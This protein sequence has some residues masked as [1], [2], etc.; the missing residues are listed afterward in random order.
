MEETWRPHHVLP[1]RKTMATLQRSNVNGV[2]GN[3]TRRAAVVVSPGQDSHEAQVTFERHQAI[4][5]QVPRTS[6]WKIAT[7]NV[8]TMHQV[9]KK[10]NVG[11]E[12]QR[13]NLDVLGL[14]EVRWPGVGGIATSDGGCFIYSAGQTTERGVGVM[15]SKPLKPCLIGY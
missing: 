13:L 6:R 8:R 14:S 12:M 7:W 1:P 3:H 10:A 2:N 9:G 15:L 5:P 11:K 4:V